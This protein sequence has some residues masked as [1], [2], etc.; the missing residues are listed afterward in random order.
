MTPDQLTNLTRQAEEKYPLYSQEEIDSRR[1][2]SDNSLRLSNVEARTKREVFIETAS[3]Y[4]EL[5]TF[6]G[7]AKSGERYGVAQMYANQYEELSRTL[8][9]IDTQL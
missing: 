3:A 5:E 1:P 6:R 9:L 8:N 4:D 2:L 7:Q